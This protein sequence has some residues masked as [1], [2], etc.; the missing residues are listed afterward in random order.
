MAALDCCFLFVQQLLKFYHVKIADNSGLF[1]LQAFDFK[2]DFNV[3]IAQNY[4]CEAKTQVSLV[5]TA[6]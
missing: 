6:A 2:E 5:R 3:N 4:W 1:E